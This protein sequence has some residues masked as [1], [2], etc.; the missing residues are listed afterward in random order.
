MNYY[1]MNIKQLK[2]MCEK[3]N[4]YGC[5]TL[6]T[7]P[8]YVKALQI[9]DRIDNLCLL[10]IPEWYLIPEINFKKFIECM[11]PIYKIME[12]EHETISNI[13]PFTK[14]V[15]VACGIN[16]KNTTKQRAISQVMGTFHQ[17]ICGLFPG[18]KDLGNGDDSKCDIGN[19]DKTEV[20]ELKNNNHTMNS[21]SREAVI[22]KLYNQK[23]LGRKSG[24]IILNDNFRKYDDEYGITW[25]CGKQF[26]QK[27]SGRKS[28]TF[29]DDLLST[30]NVC[31][32]RYKTIDELLTALETL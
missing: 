11:L 1:D 19:Y 32:E 10:I 29:M 21:S 6:K 20:Y 8:K 2:A 28:L 22:N 4:I 16:A 18:W 14:S 26:Y 12:N 25:M 9:Q 15:M 17:R 13:D 5:S 7:L 30:F 31:I 3:R 27:L 23:Q 24:I